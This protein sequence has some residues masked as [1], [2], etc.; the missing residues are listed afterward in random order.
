M[1][2]KKLLPSLNKI[3]VLLFILLIILIVSIMLYTYG[4]GLKS[5]ITQTSRPTDAF[6]DYDVVKN[7]GG[8]VFNVEFRDLIAGAGGM[9][10]RYY[11]YDL[12]IQTQDKRSAEE[13]IDERKKVVAI[14][15][16]VM[17]T[18][19]PEEMN[20]EAERSR[21]KTI[22][23]SEVTKYYPNMLVKDI[24]FTNFLYD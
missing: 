13:M 15:N 20:T 2:F 10:K 7:F 5:L 24:Y 16:E 11:R 18:F 6:R 1:N 22:I 19:P 3:I 9:K 23:Q 21:V 14:I 8:G 4:G 17:G 12:T